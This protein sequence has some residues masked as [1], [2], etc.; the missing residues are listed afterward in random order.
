VLKLAVTGG[1]HRQEIQEII[2][3]ATL[4][5]KNVVSL[6]ISTDTG[7]GA[8]LTNSA[9]ACLAGLS[10]LV[11]IAATMTAV[12]VTSTAEPRWIILASHLPLMLSFKA[13]PRTRFSPICPRWDYRE[14]LVANNAV[15]FYEGT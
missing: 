10:L 5:R 3:S 9:I 14:W 11:P 12:V 15:L 1:M 8:Y 7:I 2:R 13:R 6:D 4:K